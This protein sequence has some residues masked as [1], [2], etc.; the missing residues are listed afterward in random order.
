MLA[1]RAI[2]SA[3]YRVNRS[4]RIAWAGSPAKHEDDLNAGS[5]AL[6][7]L[8][9]VGLVGSL[10]EPVIP[11]EL[12]HVTNKADEHGRAIRVRIDRGPIFNR[13]GGTSPDWDPL[14]FVP[15]YVA[16]FADYG[17]PNEAV[18][19]GA[20]LPVIR[21]WMQPMKKRFEDSVERAGRELKRKAREIGREGGQRLWREAN[22]HTSSGPIVPYSQDVR[23]EVDAF[24]KRNEGLEN[25]YN[26][27]KVFR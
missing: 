26:P 3:L 16:R 7:Q 13:W 2:C 4:A 18:T 14:F 1:P 9:P 17:I 21:R 15:V 6:V 8:F 10:D 22:K 23:K 27:H 25:Y 24:F 19:C 20:F 5:F 11:N 12:W